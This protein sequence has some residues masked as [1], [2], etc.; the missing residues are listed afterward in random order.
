MTIA[1]DQTSIPA[2]T[3]HDHILTRAGVDL[4]D[5]YRLPWA[6]GVMFQLYPETPIYVRLHKRDQ[7]AV[8]NLGNIRSEVAIFATAEQVDRLANL[9]AAVRDRLR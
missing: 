9:L 6:L 4:D 1:A 8:I 7:R 5:R 3:A 2:L